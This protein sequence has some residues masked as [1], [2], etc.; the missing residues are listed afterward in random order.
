MTDVLALIAGQENES[1]TKQ[2]LELMTRQKNNNQSIN[3]T[4]IYGDCLPEINK[5]IS[6]EEP[7][8]L[9]AFAK[10]TQCLAKADNLNR[11]AQIFGVSNEE[12][13]YR[14]IFSINQI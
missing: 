8:G 6:K 3:I 4:T 7:Q 12:N 14:A 10:L 11:I 1:M 9:S 2:N 13:Y 5:E